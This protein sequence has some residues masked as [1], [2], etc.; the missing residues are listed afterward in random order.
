MTNIPKDRLPL[1]CLSLIERM[2][3]HRFPFLMI[4]KVVDL[5]ANTSAIGIKNITIN[6]QYFQGHFPGMPVLP[7]VLTIEAMAQTAAV[8]VNYS[9]DMID[10]NLSIFLMAVDGAK[11]RKLVIPGDVLELHMTV[12]RG[13]GQFW[14]LRGIA[15]VAGKVVAEAIITAYWEKQGAGK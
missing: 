1:A 6:E 11:F 5:V 2:I 4:D 10:D 13:R 15:K 14:K 9:L 3:P 7:G 12:L 8:L